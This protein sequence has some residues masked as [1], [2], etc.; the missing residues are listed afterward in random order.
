MKKKF[1]ITNGIEFQKI[2]NKKK[3]V[4]NKSF[5]IYYMER[6]E[7]ASRVG[8]SVGKKIG[9]AHVR[10]KVKRQVRMMFQNLLSKQLDKDM[11]CIIRAGYCHQSYEENRKLLENLVF[12]VNIVVDEI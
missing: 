2:I 8:I 7:E 5:V 1:R 12:K 6:K 10:N 4:A 9:N 3:F 11:I